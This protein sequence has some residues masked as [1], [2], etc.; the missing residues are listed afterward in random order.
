MSEK[1]R[2]VAVV[3]REDWERMKRKSASVSNKPAVEPPPKKL[4]SPPPVRKPLPKSKS[5][6]EQDRHILTR[7]EAAKEEELVEVRQA[8]RIILA[9]KCHL[10]RSAQIAEKNEL[11]REMSQEDARYDD[12]ME[13]ELQQAYEKAA[14]T[15]KEKQKQ[16]QEHAEFIQRQLEARALEREKQA[17]KIKSEADYL[18]QMRRKLKVNEEQ[19]TREK[20]LRREKLKKDLRQSYD[21]NQK[22]KSISFEKE[23]QAEMKIQEYVREQKRREDQLI[24]EKQIRNEKREQEFLKMCRVQRQTKNSQDEKFEKWLHREMEQKEREFRQKE[25]EAA[26][27]RQKF[28]EEILKERKMQQEEK[29]SVQVLLEVNPL[30]V[31]SSFPFRNASMNRSCKGSRWNMR[32]T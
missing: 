7:A 22:M 6:S 5:L 8:N 30:S 27:K 10:I 2:K 23:R 3:S 21:M 11:K 32:K 24:R 26:L 1:K 25:L 28:Q 15:D 31:N 4:E 9:A 14:E 12:I 29:V 20:F 13:R 17:A 16:N 18:E 19:V